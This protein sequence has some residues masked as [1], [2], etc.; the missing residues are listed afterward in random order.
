MRRFVECLRCK[1][2]VNL[3][4]DIRVAGFMRS[5]FLY[6]YSDDVDMV[7]LDDAQMIVGFVVGC[8]DRE[9]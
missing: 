3:L 2:M 5:C 7:I 8:D 4:V 9:A 6:F 1:L